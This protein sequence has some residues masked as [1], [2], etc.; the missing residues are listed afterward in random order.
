MMQI[1]D[2][3][4]ARR[5]IRAGDHPGHTGASRR[6][7]CRAN[8]CILPKDFALDFAAF[9]RRNPN[10]CPNGPRVAEAQR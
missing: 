1:D 8:F 6:S 3:R 4:E 10:P 7:M 5:I 9:C 2:P